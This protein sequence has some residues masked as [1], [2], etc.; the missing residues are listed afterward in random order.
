MTSQQLAYPSAGV[1]ATMAS[2][3]TL[4]SELAPRAPGVNQRAT[5]DRFAGY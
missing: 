2:H 5:T 4:T 3:S 1:P